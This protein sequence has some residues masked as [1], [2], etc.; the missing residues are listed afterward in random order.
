[1]AKGDL[2]AKQQK[3]V[4]LVL[5][6]SNQ[7]DAYRTAYNAKNM[8]EKSLW[9]T[10]CKLR[11]N[12]KVALRLRE[13]QLR[14]AQKVDLDRSWVIRK[15]MQNAEVCLADRTVKLILRK[16]GQPGQEGNNETE[17]I[18]V[19]RHNPDAANKALE[20]LGKEIGMFIERSE[21]GQPGEFADLK[22]ED[23]REAMVKEA[24]SLGFNQVAK[25]IKS[26]MVV[27]GE[28]VDAD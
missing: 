14:A 11:A 7:S 9:V 6:G 8:S 25:M 4:E 23:L 12:S 1:M 26:A 15:L 19:H 27:E 21:V 16:R 24:Q 22:D 3:F 2:T 20:L 5:A 10:A 17:T 28:V 18:E 13:I